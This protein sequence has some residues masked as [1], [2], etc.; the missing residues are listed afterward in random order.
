M[1]LIGKDATTKTRAK[2]GETMIHDE[3]S[4][5]PMSKQ[6]KWQL[7][8]LKNGCC[9]ICGEPAEGGLCLRH[10]VMA[11]EKQRERVGAKRRNKSLS[12]RLEDQ[13]GH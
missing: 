13:Q 5:K 8:Q 7:R 10:M 6:R 3:F 9:P 12:Y 2:K 1:I 11:R 4:N